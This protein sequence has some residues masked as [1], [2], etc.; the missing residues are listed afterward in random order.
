MEE[1]IFKDK[2]EEQ[3]GK[4][5]TNMITAMA[6]IIEVTENTE[7]L[8]ITCQRHSNDRKAQ[9]QGLLEV[10]E[11]VRDLQQG[12]K[13]K[14]VRPDVEKLSILINGTRLISENRVIRLDEEEG[15]DVSG[16]GEEGSTEGEEDTAGTTQ[17]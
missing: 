11:A 7:L 10:L 12:E 9:D 13:G 3:V 15:P 16:V 6:K 4:G 8:S 17:E 5:E 2:L 1:V 14:T